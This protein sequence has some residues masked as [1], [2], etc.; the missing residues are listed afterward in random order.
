MSNKSGKLFVEYRMDYQIER[1]QR[2][3]PTKDIKYFL[4]T[5]KKLTEAVIEGESQLIPS[6]NLL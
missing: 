1:I 5:V 4:L 6:G 2:K 3:L